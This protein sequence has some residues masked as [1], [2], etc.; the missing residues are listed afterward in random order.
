MSMLPPS[1]SMSSGLKDS[2]S[3]WS[4]ALFVAPAKVGFH[5]RHLPEN[6]SHRGLTR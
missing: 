3:I 6:I 2:L 1:L 4:R 5:T